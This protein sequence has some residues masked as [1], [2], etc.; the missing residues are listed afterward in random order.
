MTITSMLILSNGVLA[1]ALG[2]A[3][4]VIWSLQARITELERSKRIWF[5]MMDRFHAEPDEEWFEDLP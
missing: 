4:A 3:M 1:I 5:A 2:V